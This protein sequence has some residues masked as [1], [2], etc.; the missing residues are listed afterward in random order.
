MI[1]PRSIL[2]FFQQLY[3]AWGALA[4]M[5]SY[6]FIRGAII[7]WH[8]LGGSW[9]SM[10]REWLCVPRYVL[11]S[12]WRDVRQLAKRGKLAPEKPAD[13]P[14]DAGHLLRFFV[15]VSFVSIGILAILLRNVDR[16]A[17]SIWIQ[18]GNVA[19]VSASMV[20][21]LG[22]LYIRWWERPRLWRW[23]VMGTL[24]WILA[25]TAFRIWEGGL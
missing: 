15:G 8:D 14:Y 24:F 23:T 10:L 18:A 6:H 22:H 3:L 4:V 11:C 13:I 2:I 1:E 25:G 20:A 17:W 7:S 21:A 16:S 19:V 5:V 9:R 12:S